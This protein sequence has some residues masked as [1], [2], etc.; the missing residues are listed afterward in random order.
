MR[1]GSLLIAGLS[2][3]IIWTAAGCGL[4]NSLLGRE[5]NPNQWLQ[6]NQARIFEEQDVPDP[7]V[8]PFTHFAAGQLFEEQKKI[9]RAI[10]Q[11]RKAID[12]NPKF[13]GA[14]NRLAICLDKIGQHAEAESTLRRAIKLNPKLAYLRNNLA[15]SLMA[16]KRWG[17]SERELR[18]VLQLKPNY[19]RARVNLGIVMSKLAR[20]EE[21]FQQ[22]QM[23]LGDARAHYNIGLLDKSG[24]RYAQ[25]AESF[26]DAIAL[27]PNF[28][29]AKIQLEKLRKIASVAPRELERQTAHVAPSLSAVA[30]PVPPRQPPPV[31]TIRVAV[32]EQQDHEQQIVAAKLPTTPLPSEFPEQEDAVV[33][34]GVAP[35]AEPNISQMSIERAT[36][37]IGA[38][39]IEN[40]EPDFSWEV[41]N[42]S[43]R[44]PDAPVDRPIP[45][46]KIEIPVT[47]TT[48]QAPAV[49]LATPIPVQ[50]QR[51]DPVPTA[52]PAE[53]PEPTHREIEASTVPFLVY[54]EP[55]EVRDVRYSAAQPRYQHI[56]CVEDELVDQFLLG[57]SGFD[58]TPNLATSVPQPAL[59]TNM[60]DHDA[61]ARDKSDA[62]TPAEWRRFARE[63]HLASDGSNLPSVLMRLRGNWGKQWGPLHRPTVASAPAPTMP[64]PA[65]EIERSVTRAP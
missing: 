10:L 13:I 26:R 49:A 59:A 9:P 44:T 22:F 28:K 8:E 54:E 7:E 41:A 58:M 39:E 29:A 24:G 6:Q 23:V 27:E 15:F 38:G 17:D 12:L 46:A 50:P 55:C 21:A 60:D 25:A 33:E 62:W 51:F 2:A 32:E 64:N 3:S 16:Q 20:R 65:A 11:Y 47:K 14:H 48:V 4:M 19:Q 5:Q 61:A 40:H 63:H 1:L 42:V 43:A 31:Q 52:P 56:P 34:T 37:T 35:Q 36:D 30:T 53:S 57:E 18:A 45:A